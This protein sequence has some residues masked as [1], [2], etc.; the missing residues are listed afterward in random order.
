MKEIF[1]QIKN[2]NS[3]IEFVD[4]QPFEFI[5]YPN[6]SDDRLLDGHWYR[7]KV[8]PYMTM[9]ATRCYDFMLRYNNNCPM[10]MDSM[11]GKVLKSNRSMVY[12]QLHDSLS[13]SK[14]E[15]WIVRSAITE[16]KEIVNE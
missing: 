16:F 13:R 15:G 4:G 7:I 2:F 10:P 3:T 14:W 1:N 5:L 6:V 11:S 8:R 9:T 12:M